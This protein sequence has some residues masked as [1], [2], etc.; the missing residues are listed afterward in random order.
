[1]CFK[2]LFLSISV[3]VK[4]LFNCSSG[5]N[6]TI[7]SFE[8]SWKAVFTSCSAGR[9]SSIFINLSWVK[10]NRP[11]CK[12][13]SS[14]SGRKTS[15][16]WEDISLKIMYLLFSSARLKSSIT[17]AVLVKIS[18]A[19]AIAFWFPEAASASTISSIERFEY[20]SWKVTELIPSFNL[21]YSR[22]ESIAKL[23]VLLNIYILKI[24]T[25]RNFKNF[26][27]CNFL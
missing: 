14:I 6:W 22:L 27:D 3:L 26:K 24:I 25:A 10:K 8:K 2:I 17:R 12:S 20:F 15:N 4:N 11:W 9:C 21:K 23:I 7:S 5:I 18:W 19:S 13:F 1:M 16:C